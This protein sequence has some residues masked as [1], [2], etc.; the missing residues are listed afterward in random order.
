LITAVV[1]FLP[2]GACAYAGAYFDGALFARAVLVSVLGGALL[3]AF[4]FVLFKIRARL[5]DYDE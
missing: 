1:L 2:L 4:P 3:M 5:P